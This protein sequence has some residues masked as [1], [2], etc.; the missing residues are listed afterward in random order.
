MAA[1][2]RRLAIVPRTVGPA[3]MRTPQ[4]FARAASTLAFHLQC[5]ATDEGRFGLGMYGGTEPDGAIVEVV[6]VRVD[7]DDRRWDQ[8][9][10]NGQNVG[11]RCGAVQRY[12]A[13]RAP[14][15]H[16]LA[17]AAT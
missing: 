12:M 11:N 1:H 14:L 13:L 3:N 2:A 9:T 17:R 10:F 5:L 6:I 7:G 4:T 16:A 15:L 8:V